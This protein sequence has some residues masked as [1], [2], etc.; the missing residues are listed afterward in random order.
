MKA[1]FQS[2]SVL[3]WSHIRILNA[4]FTKLA[5]LIL[6]VLPLLAEGFGWFGISFQHF[7]YPICGALLYLICCALFTMACPKVVRQFKDETE[8]QNRCV[9]DKSKLDFY[10][11]FGATKTLTT[12]DVKKWFG[13]NDFL[14]PL[15]AGLHLAENECIRSHANVTYKIA[16]RSRIL[17]RYAIAGLFAVSVVSMEYLMIHRLLKVLGEFSI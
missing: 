5:V 16:D 3:R 14:H 2:L 6:T 11:E 10:E 7:K 1:K 15:Q 4:K 12:D 8:Y 17:A 13:S 9:A